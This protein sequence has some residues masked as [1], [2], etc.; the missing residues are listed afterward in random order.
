MEKLSDTI[1]AVAQANNVAV[2]DLWH[3]SGIN[4]RTWSVFGAQKNAVNEQYAKYQMD[5]SGR[6]VG[7]APQRYVNGQS[8]YQKRN[9]SII[10]EKYTGSSPYPFNGDQLH[11]STEGYARIGECVVGSVIRAFGKY[12]STVFHAKC[13]LFAVK[14]CSL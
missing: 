14:R 8:Y 3:E 4:R 13:L 6:V 2:C 5:A 1:K 9:G 7:S 12:I 10:L 11:C